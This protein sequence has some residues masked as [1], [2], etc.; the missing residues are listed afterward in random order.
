[1]AILEP[2][3]TPRFGYLIVPVLFSVLITSRLV[4][5]R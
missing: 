2:L 5:I 3:F 1:M 4:Q